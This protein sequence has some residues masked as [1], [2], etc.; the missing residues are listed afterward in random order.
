M[1]EPK[2]VHSGGTEIF[3]HTDSTEGAVIRK[4][5][6]RAGRTHHANFNPTLEAHDSCTRGSGAVRV[7]SREFPEP[8]VAEAAST[9]GG[10]ES[11]AKREQEKCSLL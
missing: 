9:D 10:A 7:R 5:R 3:D 2:P 4:G 11:R 1:F 8:L 6:W